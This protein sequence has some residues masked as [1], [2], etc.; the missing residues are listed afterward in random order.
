MTSLSSIYFLLP[1]IERR[2]G[3]AFAGFHRLVERGRLDRI[4]PPINRDGIFAVELVEHLFGRAV[5]VPVEDAMVVA[6]PHEHVRDDFC[7]AVIKRFQDFVALGEVEFRLLQVDEAIDDF[8][9]K[10]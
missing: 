7:K 2:D 9:L 10:R 6:L 3:Q 8:V 5:A 1:N 4:D